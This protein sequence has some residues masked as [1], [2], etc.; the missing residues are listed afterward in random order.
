MATTSITIGTTEQAEALYAFPNNPDL[1]WTLCQTIEHWFGQTLVRDGYNPE[2]GTPRITAA[3]DAT[4]GQVA[5]TLSAHDSLSGALEGYAVKLPGFLSAAWDAYANV[6]PELERDGTWDPRGS[7]W[8]FFLPV[9]LPM[10]NQ[11][12]VQFF[13]YPPV[14]MLEAMQDY[15]DDPVPYRVEELLIQNG[16]SDRAE[17]RL[18]EAIIDGAPIAA[19]DDAGSAPG[20]DPRWGLIPIQH[21]TGYQR[22]ML[23]TLLRPDAAHPG[24]TIPIVVYGQHPREIFGIEF[25]GGSSVEINAPT[26]V[27]ILAGLK[28]PVIG[29]H[30]PYNFYWSA[31]VDQNDPDNTSVGDGRMVES[32]CAKVEGLMRADLISAAWQKEMARDP[33]Q[34]GTEVMQRVTALWRE[35]SNA[36]TVCAMTPHQATLRYS[37]PEK[38]TFGFRVDLAKARAECTAHE[39]QTCSFIL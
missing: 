14:K 15:L 2:S 22:Q 1:G 20:G 35:S 33:S 8:R 23:L 36:N 27:E 29:A 4:A 12:S 9:G 39:N 21:F 26:I 10:L 5:L 7:G 3:A 13:H 38:T 28:T 18:Y 6:I 30:H 32:H 11:R 34:N 17:A 25:L 37:D 19:P 16:V 24:Y 31:Q